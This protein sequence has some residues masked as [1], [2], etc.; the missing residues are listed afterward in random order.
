[1]FAW[2]HNFETMQEVDMPSR[3]PRTKGTSRDAPRL[4]SASTAKPKV[5]VQMLPALGALIAK[6]ALTTEAADEILAV[7]ARDGSFVS[8]VLRERYPKIRP[9][10]SLEFAFVDLV[11]VAVDPL[12]VAAIPETLSHRHGVLPIGFNGNR[13][14]VACADAGNVVALDDIGM[15]SGREIEFVLARP[16]GIHRAWQRFDAVNRSTQSM[17]KEVDEL[18]PDE[19]AEVVEFE[20]ADDAPVVRAINQLIAQAVHEGASDLHIEP[21]EHDVLVRFRLDGVL[22][23]VMRAPK[24]FNGG[25]TSRL[26]VM[27]NLNIAERRVPQDG[28]ITVKVDRQP[29]D[30]RVAT[31]PSVW[32]EEVILRILDRS[33]SLLT[34]SELGFKANTLARYEHAFTKPHGAVLVVGPTG[35]GKSTTLYSTLSVIRRPERK[36]IT[37][38]DPVELT[39][40]G[41]SQINVNPRAGLTFASALRSILRSDPDVVMVGEIRDTETARIAIQAAMTG[42]LVLSTLHTNDAPSALSRLVEMQVEPF[43]VASS[44]ECVL[45]Q[46]LARKLCPRCREEREAPANVIAEAGWPR[47]TRVFRAVGCNECSG[48]GYRGRVALVELMLMSE[49]IERLVA[50]RG[51][52]EDIRK[53]ALAQGMRSL[54]D[55][56]MDKVRAG[57]TSF[58]EVMRIVEGQALP[59]EAAAPVLA[60]RARKH[61]PRKAPRSPSADAVATSPNAR[62]RR[63]HEP[64]GSKRISPIRTHHGDSSMRPSTPSV[65]STSSSG[66]RV[67]R[68]RARRLTWPPTPT[69]VRSIF[70]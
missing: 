61:S 57:V 59:A 13:L 19:D 34:L 24:R 4:R 33:S 58:E 55:D 22:H 43:L 38:E 51:T 14:I 52:A 69:T 35:S 47:K 8:D 54:R 7:A 27:A 18:D 66:R 11:E 29:V 60:S 46:R 50:D 41:M 68:R 6:G 48:T 1:V 56:G 64:S 12:A 28:R 42:H 26:K 21:E 53:V 65:R 49:E 2:E 20:S 10:A 23:D 67:D 40:P 36:I 31:I 39:L 25:M 62:R 32:G 70:S 63:C 45:A 5:P 16:D 44:I 30:L 15:A 37:I 3:Q 17:L 9:P